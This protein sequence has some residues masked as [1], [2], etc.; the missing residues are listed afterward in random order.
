MVPSAKTDA[1]YDF[2]QLVLLELQISFTNW[3]MYSLETTRNG[4][5]NGLMRRILG[6]FSMAKSSPD[7]RI[8]NK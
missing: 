5:G 1:S 4:K 3:V 7:Q 2:V 8:C 6:D